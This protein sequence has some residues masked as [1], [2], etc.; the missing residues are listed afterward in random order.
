MKLSFGESRN[1]FVSALIREDQQESLFAK[2]IDPNQP[3]EY[4][5]QPFDIEYAVIKYVFRKKEGIVVND[6]INDE[7]FPYVIEGEELKNR[8][9]ICAPIN[10]RHGIRGVI[11]ADKSKLPLCEGDSISP[12]FEEQQ[13]K[14]LILEKDVKE[15]MLP[16]ALQVQ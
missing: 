5:T 13:L 8:Q 15:D 11:Y 10:S 7:R 14:L 4:L 6:I 2:S 9:I 3:D 16:F 12:P 1:R